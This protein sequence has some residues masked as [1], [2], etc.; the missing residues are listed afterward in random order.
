MHSY[1]LYI[2]L[3]TALLAVSV[4]QANVKL[5]G[6]FCDNMV[7]QR[8]ANVP[9]W[10]QASPDEKVTVT[11]GN[12]QVSATADTQGRWAVKLASLP[13]GGPVE[14][15]VTGANTITLRNVLI[16]DVW[17]CGGQSNMVMA[18]YGTLGGE[19][20]AA[21]A[22][23]PNIRYFA[24]TVT[25][26]L[27]PQADC[28]GKWVPCDPGQAR[29]FS[30]VAYYFGREL[31]KNLNVPIGLIFNGLN[32]SV[33]EAW[34]S[35]ETLEADPELKVSLG[36]W[37]QFLQK[38]AA[39]TLEQTLPALQE[40]AK[41]AE[42]AKA[43][44]KP[45][46]IP[47]LQNTQR[48]P[49]S[50]VNIIHRMVTG[51][52]YGTIVPISPFAIKGV[53]WY[54]G[55]HNA[56]R[57]VQ[58]RKLLPAMIKC[59][60]QTW[61]QGDFPFLFVQLPNYYAQQTAPEESSWA[62]TREAQAM[63]LALPSTGMAVSI[64]VG[65]AGNIHPPNKAPVGTRLS[66]VA[67]AKVYGK[68]IEYAG[69]TYTGMTVEGNTVRLRF[70]H[71]GGGLVTKNGEPLKGFT[72]A[73]KDKKWCWAEAKIDGDTIVLSSDKVAEP[74]AVRYAW[75]SNPICNLYNKAGLPAGPF[76]TDSW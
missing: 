49:R 46:P 2:L 61:G 20:E 40:W 67:L 16:G 48:D 3:V 13:A 57:P 45:L 38:Y 34:S 44:G 50:D 22:K 54:Q 37:D 42:K 18:L 31:H 23:Y 9:V 56:D 63:A 35:R 14:V 29:G 28:L 73:G 27:E 43:D 69:P 71:L 62:M 68:N 70:D 58:Y 11:L 60:R 12:Q 26:A 47:P 10:G 7:L 21:Q 30:A 64:D 39:N 17:V 25:A 72:I 1:R 55:E 15:T 5:N 76:R 24:Q 65:E 59:W 32:G 74:V 53:I 6:L 19:A 51:L 41:A 4:L 75:A 66:L 8:D 36:Y 52:Y 33:A